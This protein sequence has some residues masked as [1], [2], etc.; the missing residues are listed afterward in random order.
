MT[1]LLA[2]LIAIVISAVLINYLWQ[3]L[4]ASFFRLFV[5]PGVIIHEISHTIGAIITGAKVKKISLFQKK[6]GYIL[7]TPSPI[8][9]LGQMVI[10]L[11]PLLGG[12]ASLFL[13]TY[14]IEPQLL[15]SIS[16]HQLD[17]KTILSPWKILFQFPWFDFKS[18][19]Y[20]YLVL[21]V[22]TCLNPSLVDLK[23]I[24]LSLAALIIILFFTPLYHLL[25]SLTII[26]DLTNIFGLGLI[27]MIFLLIFSI[28][29]Y[30]L[31]KLVT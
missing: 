7:H 20:L 29:L 18:W 24:I 6:G 9:I 23:Y 16:A 4:S 8:P 10:S 1:H 21:S 11:A 17:L 5:A 22:S 30:V 12:I 26:N 28:I 15:K 19:L 2:Y 3:H 31:K 14:W 25:N 27:L 13:L